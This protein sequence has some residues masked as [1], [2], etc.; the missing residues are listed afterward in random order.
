LIDKNCCNNSPKSFDFL[1]EKKHE[2]LK[3][4]CS[5]ISLHYYFCAFIS[6]IINKSIIILLKI[7]QKTVLFY[8]EIKRW[9]FKFIFLHSLSIG[10]R[11]LH[12]TPNIKSIF[13]CN[14]NARRW[15]LCFGY[16][17]RK[18]LSSLPTSMKSQLYKI[19][20]SYNP[21]IGSEF[22]STQ[23]LLLT[24]LGGGCMLKR[25]FP[26]APGVEEEEGQFCSYLPSLTRDSPS[27][28]T[29]PTHPRRAPLACPYA[30]DLLPSWGRRRG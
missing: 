28:R 10:K 21:L 30:T 14:Y 3:H 6:F 1:E 5:N 4:L 16:T 26:A 23:W 8:I 22:S 13:L 27:M 11:S 2:S 25:V 18:N 9:K 17:W 20:G 12:L 19:I 24:F 29:H 15:F 7:V